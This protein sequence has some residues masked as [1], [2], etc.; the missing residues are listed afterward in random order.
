MPIV[1]K[2]AFSFPLGLPMAVMKMNTTN[3]IMSNPF[4][5]YTQDLYYVG[6]ACL[7]QK[8]FTSY[9]EWLA[10]GGGLMKGNP[11]SSLLRGTCS[12]I[13]S[14]TSVPLANGGLGK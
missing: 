9:K 4:K 14:P 5:L 6:T 1:S 8:R 13:L 7:P 10:G 11:K 3:Q 12:L 2:N